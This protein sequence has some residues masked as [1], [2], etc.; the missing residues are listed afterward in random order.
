MI[1]IYLYIYAPEED[2]SRRRNNAGLTTMGENM[3]NR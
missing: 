1:D 2:R 3:I